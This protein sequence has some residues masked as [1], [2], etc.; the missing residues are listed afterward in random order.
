MGQKLGAFGCAIV[1]V[2]ACVQWMSAEEPSTASDAL[3]AAA[4]LGG[5]TPPQVRHWSLVTSDE[6]AAKAKERIENVLRSP[7]KSPMDFVDVPINQV[8]QLL[9]EE[10]DI[11]IVYD[12]VA[13]DAIAASPEVE[14][15]FQ[16]NNVTVG[17]A[18]DLML[19]GVE[20]V[21]YVID[22]QVLLITTEEEAQKRMETRI[23]RI[24]DLV[25]EP[26]TGAETLI[27]LIRMNVK[28][29]SW[30]NDGKDGQGQIMSFPPGMLIISQTSRIQQQVDALL[31]TLRKMKAEIAADPASN[32]AADVKYR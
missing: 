26:G 28:R 17:M 5:S 13:L 20:D 11:P 30:S 16:I 8:T 29:D 14:V 3:A 23:Y 9:A 7:L 15:T 27:Q 10:Y 6:A 18:L 24:D 19:R 1:V 32:A 22:H 4:T 21:T 25:N 12:T 31:S 2:V